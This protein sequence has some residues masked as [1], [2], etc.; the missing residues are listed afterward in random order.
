MKTYRN[1]AMDFIADEKVITKEDYDSL[2]RNTNGVE[3]KLDYEQ[4]NVLRYIFEDGSFVAIR[5]SGTE[6]KVKFYFALAGKTQSDA[7]ARHDKIKQAILDY[8]KE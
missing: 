1:S 7:I 8:I 3:E 5:P 6:P 2:I 4:S